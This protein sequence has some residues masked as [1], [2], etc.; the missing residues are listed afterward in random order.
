MIQKH[1]RHWDVYFGSAAFAAAALW[2]LW[3]L[4]KDWA[5]FVQR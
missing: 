3:T 4:L 5:R 2:F 1:E